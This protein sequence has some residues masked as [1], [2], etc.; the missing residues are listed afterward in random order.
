MNG[1]T[2]QAEWKTLTVEA[3]SLAAQGELGQAIEAGEKAL[4]AAELELGADHAAVRRPSSPTWPFCTRRPAPT[5]RRPRSTSG[6]LRCARRLVGGRRSRRRSRSGESGSRLPPAWA[7][8][9]LR[10]L[11]TRRRSP[12]ERRRSVP[13]TPGWPP[14]STISATFSSPRA[15]SRMLSTSTGGPLPSARTRSVRAIPGWPPAWTGSPRCTK[16]G[17]DYAKADKGFQKSLALRKAALGA[18][19]PAVALSLQHLADL[20]A[21]R[22]RLEE[23]RA[24][25]QQALE[26]LEAAARARR[27]ADRRQPR[28]AGRLR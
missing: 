24:G 13:I 12:S 1:R 18:G 3:S 15:G 17:R 6:P 26:L 27:P 5:C 25:H 19:D 22:G 16:L 28:R 23:A 10:P 20:H 8:R 7:R 9:R 21:Q 4:A 14:P 2:S 11:S